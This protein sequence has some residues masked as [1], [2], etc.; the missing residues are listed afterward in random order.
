MVTTSEMTEI[1]K[2]QVADMTDKEKDHVLQL[3]KNS[4]N[5]TYNSDVSISALQDDL[6]ALRRRILTIDKSLNYVLTLTQLTQSTNED[7]E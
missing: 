3:L 2:K 6:L 7:E 5:T 4:I 1:L